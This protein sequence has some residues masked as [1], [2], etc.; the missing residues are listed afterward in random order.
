MCNNV[1]LAIFRRANI[2]EIELISVQVLHLIVN[3]RVLARGNRV[4]FFELGIR[5]GTNIKLSF[6]CLDSLKRMVYS[7]CGPIKTVDKLK[8]S[9][10][11]TL[12]QVTISSC[13]IDRERVITRGKRPYSPSPP[14]ETILLETISRVPLIECKS[15]FTTA[16]R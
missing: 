12:I 6:I 9:N 7:L 4:L 11:G 2:A 16:Q 15:S 1:D 5:S 10:T 13:S 3:R 14:V 8:S